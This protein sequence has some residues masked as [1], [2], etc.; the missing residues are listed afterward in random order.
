MSPPEKSHSPLVER[1]A[2]MPHYHQPSRRMTETAIAY[3]IP[4]PRGSQHLEV[5]RHHHALPQGGSGMQPCSSF[6]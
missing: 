5:D 3:A 2:E 6:R 1:G 4:P